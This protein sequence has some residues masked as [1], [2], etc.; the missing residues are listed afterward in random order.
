MS[1]DSFAELLAMDGHALY[2]WASY[3]LALLVLT[4]NALVPVLYHR[5][6]LHQQWQQQR[7]AQARE[8][9]DAAAGSGPQHA[10]ETS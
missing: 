4:A 1:F 2:V 5:R 9:V 7:R 3:G 10:Q 8:A 6:L